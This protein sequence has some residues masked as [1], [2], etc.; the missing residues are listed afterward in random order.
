MTEPTPTVWAGD[1]LETSIIDA[2][3]ESIQANRA[4]PRD[5]QR[6]T[7]ARAALE[8]LVALRDVGA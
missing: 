4:R 1:E 6:I 3:R 8:A 5:P 2:M 7:D